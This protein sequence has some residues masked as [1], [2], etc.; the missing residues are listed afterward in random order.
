MDTPKYSLVTLDVGPPLRLLS[1]L[2]WTELVRKLRLTPQQAR[3]VA[4]ILQGKRDKQIAAAMGLSMAT[5]R[6]HLSRIFV[7]VGADD[8]VGLVL[9]V[10]AGCREL[11]GC[12]A[13]HQK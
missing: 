8:R 6:T 3:I 4:Y 7:R 5:V 10:F 11:R 12:R 1:P 9:R 13:C 2:E